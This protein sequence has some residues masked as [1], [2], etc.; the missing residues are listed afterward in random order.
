M[1]FK[2]ISMNV[3]LIY[4]CE[5]QTFLVIKD[6][7]NT[8][9]PRVDTR[10]PKPLLEIL[11]IYGNYFREKTVLYHAVIGFSDCFIATPEFQI[12]SAKSINMVKVFK[13]L[14]KS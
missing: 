4:A 2:N 1:R 14:A 11:P 13:Y 8:V 10:L 9:K 5:L 7:A 12:C 3:W 6:D